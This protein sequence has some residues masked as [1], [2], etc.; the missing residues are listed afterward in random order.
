M[1]VG[2]LIG[3][4][5][6]RATGEALRWQNGLEASLTR[7]LFHSLGRYGL[8]ESTFF[9]DIAP[10]LDGGDL[11]LLKKNTKAAFFEPLVGAAGHA[12]A[13]VLDRVR[14]GTDSGLDGS[15]R[16]DSTGGDHRRVPRRAA[17]CVADISAAAPR[18]PR[19]TTPK[20]SCSRPSRSAGR[21]SGEPADRPA[22]AAARD[23]AGR[24]RRRS[25]DRRSRLPVS[26][27][28][29]HRQAA[30]R[31]RVDAARRRRGWLR[32]R[33]HAV[34]PAR[35]SLAGRSDCDRRWAPPH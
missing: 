11:E 33:N 8:K 14:H 32:R 25:T 28:P 19:A 6:R 1:K 30:D 31:A 24:G 20:R 22:P 27:N 21:R 3:L 4:T 9:D 5:V 15:G 2:E 26:S 35:R 18:A 7:G 17:G 34:R 10:F 23:P 12:L 13:T 16:H 29:A